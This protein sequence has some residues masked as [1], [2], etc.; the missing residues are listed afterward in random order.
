MLFG[1][2]TD[3]KKRQFISYAKKIVS[4]L[5]SKGTEI[6]VEEKLAKKIGLK[7]KPIK[8]IDA[9]ML[10]C[11]GDDGVILKTLLE[12][13]D[14]QVP[15]L[16]VRTPGNLGFLAETSTTN[17]DTYIDNILEGNWKVEERSRIEA[18]VDGEKLPPVLNEIAIFAKRSATLIHYSLKINE[19]FM[20][21]DSADGVIVST[22]SGSTAYALSAGGPIVTYDTP[23]L[24]VV[25]VNSLNQ[26]RRPLVVSDNREIIIDEI[27]SPVT[28]E[29]ILD[30][31]IRR[32]IEEETVKVRK[33]KYSALFVK[34]SEGVFTPLKEKLYMKVRQWEE[35]ET[36]PP[37][38][39]LVLKV[40]EYEGPMTQKEIAEKTLLPRR[41]VR[42]AL[43]I[44]LQKEL[45]VKRAML[46][47][48]RLSIYHI[49][50]FDEV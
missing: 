14:K 28:C 17:F 18:E 42:N 9:D 45:I 37:S 19:E 3:V 49:K 32:N 27:E 26:A 38:A 48:T 12:L 20:W 29:I 46:R 10:I 44:L 1:V 40:L 33:S 47:D 34:L 8:D 25:P 15:L 5:K 6:V 41:T 50:E 39:K 35:R 13:Q 22:P 43:K 21:R 16:G 7:G 11:I 24:V 23:V 4:T 31:R 2:T 36:L 30:G